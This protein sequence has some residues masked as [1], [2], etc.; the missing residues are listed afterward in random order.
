VPIEKIREMGIVT[1]LLRL[2]EREGTGPI[3]ESY[4]MM[5]AQTKEIGEEYEVAQK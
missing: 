5:D 2:K 4:V 3:K 1:E